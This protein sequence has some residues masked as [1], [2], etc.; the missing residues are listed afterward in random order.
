MTNPIPFSDDD[1]LL[2]RHILDLAVR[3]EKV[4]R[5]LY[6]NFLD[7]R[8]LAICETALKSDYSF[9]TL[10]G[11]DGAERRVIAFGVD[12]EDEA[13]PPF[14]AVVFNYPEGAGLSHRDFLGSLM[15][16]GIKRELLGDILVGNKRTSVFAIN[17]ALPLIKELTKIGSCGVRITDDFSPNDIPEQEFDEIH[18]TVASLRLDSVIATALRLSREKAAELIKSKGVMHNRVMTFN[19]SEKVTEGDRFS[20]RGFGKC[21]LYKIGG[22]SKK[23]R[24]FITIRKFR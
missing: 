21:E 15:A 3:S 19:T 9:I 20:V 7:D 24:I 11:Y 23:D 6:S 12:D 16:L 4:G 22:Q 18:S 14:K 8:Q 5:P 2:V 10:G 17:S 13:F 1:K